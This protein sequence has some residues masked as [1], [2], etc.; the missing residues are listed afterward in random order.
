MRW[1]NVKKMVATVNKIEDNLIFTVNN[2]KNKY[3]VYYSTSNTME[4]KQLLII[5]D[6]EEIEVKSPIEEQRL[7]F[8]IIDGEEST[9]VFATRLVEVTTIDNFRDLGGYITEDGKTVK[10]GYFYRCASLGVVNE[11]DKAYLE[12][13]RI[14]TI[15][16]FRS[17]MEVDAEND[18]EL[19][20]C[21]YINESGIKGFDS[22]FNDKEN[23]D[24]KRLIMDVIKL[25]EK[26]KEIQEFVV[27]GYKTMVKENEAFKILFDTIK[28][29]EKLPLVFHC[30]AGKD[31]TGV[32]GALILLALGVGEDKVIEDYCLSNIYR[33]VTNEKQLSEIRKY[34]KDESIIDVIKNLFMVKKEYLMFTLA[35]I[36]EKYSTYQDYV[37]NELGVSQEELEIFRNNYLF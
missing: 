11:R 28:N 10:W 33:E 23:F 1:I 17:K 24:M 25:P 37:I 12:S 31:R 20:N 34:V 5:G 8:E 21:K 3:K 26:I 2:F 7:F 13:M 22:I 6:K 19:N 15:F 18:I 29:T 9:G 32:A 30:T 36:K 14:A 4:K 27:G 16:D 35:T